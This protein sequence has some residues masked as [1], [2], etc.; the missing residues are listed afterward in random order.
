MITHIMTVFSILAVVFPVK[1]KYVLLN[2]LKESNKYQIK[3]KIKPL[4]YMAYIINMPIDHE[5]IV[6]LTT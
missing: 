5:K 2:I 6:W 4:K 1:K 3:E